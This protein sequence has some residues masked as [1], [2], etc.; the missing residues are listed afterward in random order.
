MGPR[1]AP[2]RLARLAGS[3][4]LLA[5]VVPD[6]G[7]AQDV[8]EGIRSLTRENA[9]QYARPVTAGLGAAMNSG[10]FDGTAVG[11]FPGLSLDFRLLGALVPPEDESFAPSVPQE[12]TVEIDGRR[13][14]YQNPYG[15]PA[16]IT[17]ATVAGEGS[18]AVLGPVGQ[19]RQDLRDAGEDPSEYALRFP[20]GLGL[21]AIPM[22]VPQA[23]LTL[24]LGTEVAVR[25]LPSVRV[26]NEVGSVEAF[27]VGARH[28][29]SRWISD[30][31]PLDVA[32]SGGIQTFEAGGYLR[33]ESRIVELTVGKSLSILTLYASGGLEESEVDVRYT[34]DD[35]RLPE[36]GQ[37]IHFRTHGANDRRFTVGLSLDLLFLDL[38]ADYT[39]AEY[40]VVHASAGL[41]I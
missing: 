3:A 14:T 5:L 7:A 20:D 16:G 8:E 25:W 32:I 36:D 17:T 1:S 39:V 10:W 9:R 30:D 11:D 33:A 15:S 38:A 34:L 37:T 26:A 41:G 35:P 22:V 2:L 31:F 12:V 21:P 27:G 6:A 40:P 13:R 29:I 19:L 24:P 4:V 23:S 28:S 18:G